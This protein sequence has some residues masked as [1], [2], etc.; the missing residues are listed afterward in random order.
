MAGG[1]IYT[2]VDEEL[3]VRFSIVVELDITETKNWSKVGWYLDGKKRETLYFC[4]SD[5]WSM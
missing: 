3:G 5:N 1:E 2:C 4:Q